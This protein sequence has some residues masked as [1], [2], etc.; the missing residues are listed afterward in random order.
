MRC[1]VGEKGEEEERRET[2]AMVPHVSE[3][4]EKKK[5]AGWLGCVV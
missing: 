5:G 4:E 2:D 3:R 1:G